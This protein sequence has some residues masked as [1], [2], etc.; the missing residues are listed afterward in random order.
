MRKTPSIPHQ[1]VVDFILAGHTT[2]AFKEHFGLAND[3]IANLRVNAAFNALG[4]PRPRYAEPRLCEFCGRQFT[5]R[6][7]QQKTCGSAACQTALIVAWHKRNPQSS[8]SALARYRRTE[9]GRQNNLRMHAKRKDRGRFGSISEKWNYAAAE[10]RK[11][12]RKLKELA[13]RNSWE[14]RMQHIQ[15]ACQLVRQFNARKPRSF[16]SQAVDSQWQAAVRA[17]QTILIQE[18][19]RISDSPWERS[20]NRIAASLRTGM[21]VKSWKAN[22]PAE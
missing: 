2:R 15:K 20:T 21:K 18:S 11:N 1:T 13:T 4:I 5:A 22:R 8:A 17:L 3:N 16:P 14:Y 12:L 6:D 10:S 19:T 7:F 9:K